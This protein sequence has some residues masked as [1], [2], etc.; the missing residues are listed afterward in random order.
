LI[1]AVDLN[2][3]LQIWNIKTK[4]PAFDLMELNFE[5]SCLYSPN[6][7]LTGFDNNFLFIGSDKGDIFI[8]SLTDFTFTN[9]YVSFSQIQS[10]MNK[11]KMKNSKL[12]LVDYVLN[13]IINPSNFSEIFIAYQY[14]GIIIYNL[15]VN[16]VFNLYFNKIN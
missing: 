5:V 1:V 13:I 6:F 12:H 8:L 11:K 16:S 3:K 9:C 4:K 7:F 2:N 10:F 15:E 14:T